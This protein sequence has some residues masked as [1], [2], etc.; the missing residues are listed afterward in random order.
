[1][2]ILL[3]SEFEVV[4]AN[5]AAQVFPKTQYRL[6]AQTFRYDELVITFKSQKHFSENFRVRFLPKNKNL[7]LSCHYKGKM[8]HLNYVTAD[9]YSWSDGLGDRVFSPFNVGEKFESLAKKFYPVLEEFWLP[10]FSSKKPQ[11]W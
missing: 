9:N 8:Y 11:C 3:S 5:I 2:N 6:L 4:V 10:S 7:T 1:M